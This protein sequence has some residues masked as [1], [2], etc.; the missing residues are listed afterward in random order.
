[1]WTVSTP[2]SDIT[3]LGPFVL[4]DYAPGQRLV[5]ARNP[6]YWRKDARGVVL[7]YLDRVVIEIVPEENTELLRLQAGQSDITNSEMPPEAYATMKRA[8]DMGQVQLFDL[9]VGR[10]ADTLW[11]NLKPGVFRDDPRAAWLQRDEL[12]RA[13]SLAV[14]RQA[15]ADAVFFGAGVPIDGPITPGNR[16]WYAA[17][18]QHP[19]HDPAAAKRLLASIGLVDRDGDGMLEDEAH[20]PVRFTVITQKGRRSQERG[21]AILRDELKKIGVDVDVAMLEATAVIERIISGHYEAVYFRPAFSDSD[22][23]NN[24]DFWLSSGGQHFWNMSQKTPATDWERRIDDLTRQQVRTLDEKERIRLF[25]EV[26]SIYAEHEP[27][28]FFVAQ[29]VFTAASTRVVNVTPAVTRP[30]MLWAPDTVAVKH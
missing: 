16:K 14:D 29:R 28:L 4:T 2:P 9:G 12:R 5:F 13:I 26:Q 15:F 3:G 27:A 1:V 22:P 11:F 25:A 23:A 17:G 21:T 18:V 6:R 24:M 20:R 10:D 7:P 19:A 30:Q 8:A